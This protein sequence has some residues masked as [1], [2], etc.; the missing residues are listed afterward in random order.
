MNIAEYRKAVK[1][2][3]DAISANRSRRMRGLPTLP[4][5]DAPQRPQV[6]VAYSQGGTVYEGVLAT[7]EDCPVGCVIKWEDA[8]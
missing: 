5:P 6:A 1:A 7:P 2:R 4:V 3:Q 8:R